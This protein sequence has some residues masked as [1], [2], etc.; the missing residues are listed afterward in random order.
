MSGNVVGLIEKIITSTPNTL[1]TVLVILLV[2]GAVVGGLWLLRADFTAG[3]ISITG[4]ETCTPTP[5]APVA[6]GR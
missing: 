6:C 2:I 1:R 3:P 4:R 5:G